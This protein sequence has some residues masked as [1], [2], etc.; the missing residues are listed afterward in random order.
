MEIIQGDP[1]FD[2]EIIQGDPGRILY[3]KCLLLFWCPPW[4]KLTRSDQGTD[5][6]AVRPSASD[7][8][9]GSG[10]PWKHTPQVVLRWPNTVHKSH[11]WWLLRSMKLGGWKEKDFSS[12]TCYVVQESRN[13]CYVVQKLVVQ[14]SRLLIHPAWIVTDICIISIILWFWCLVFSSL[15]I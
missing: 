11:R 12:P 7:G 10:S 1:G 8:H 6:D 5:R 15:L 3:W 14:E 2:E 13:S 4:K 9:T